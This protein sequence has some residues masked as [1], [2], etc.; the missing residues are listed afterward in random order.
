MN[1]DTSENVVYGIHAVEELL[2]QR[3]EQVDRVYFDADRK[4]SALFNLLKLCRKQRLSYQ[5]V[6]CI[7]L[8]S[9]AKTAKH[10]GVAA[11]CSAKAYST[12]ESL[13]S[14]LK[15]KRN[16]PGLL[17]VPASIED[18]RNLGSLI[19]S[20]VAFGVDA[21]LLERKNTAPLGDTVAKASAGMIEHLSIIKPRNLEGLIGDLKAMGFFAVGAQHTATTRPE[22]VD[23]TR[24]TIIITGGEHRDIPPYLARLCSCMAGIPIS[25]AA[26]SLNV[27]VAGSVLLYEC[28]KQRGF[29]Y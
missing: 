12:V 24:P 5:N 13:M 26:Q 22:Q 7:K 17:F 19:R 9:V 27:T 3:I 20:C 10:Q 1:R 21:L 4:S 23:F 18:P 2:K 6:P 15:V 11:I 14:A 8:D 28:N 25:P 16:A 29:K